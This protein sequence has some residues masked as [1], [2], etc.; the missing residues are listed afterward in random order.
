MTFDLKLNDFKRGFIDRVAKQA[1]SGVRRGLEKMAA[2][3]RQTAKN[4]IKTAAKMS[5]KKFGNLLKTPTGGVVSRPGDPPLNH[6]GKLKNNIFFAWEE[7][8]QSVRIGPTKFNG[9][10]SSMAALEY[11]GPAPVLVKKWHGHG[12][13]PTW[14]IRTVYIRARPFM[15]P[16]LKKAMEP[17]RVKKFFERFMSDG[18]PPLSVAA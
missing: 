8:T 7:A 11:G 5:K 16:A 13:R 1:K 18:G 15:R 9:R 14:E 17:Q 10:G 2:Y 12:S 3:I 6:T 4:S